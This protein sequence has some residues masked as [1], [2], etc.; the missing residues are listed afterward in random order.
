MSAIA[1]IAEE[2]GGVR[3]MADRMTEVLGRKVAPSTVQYWVEVGYVPQKRVGDV[4]RTAQ[5]AGKTVRQQD[6]YQSIT[7]PSGEAPGEH[8][9]HADGQPKSAA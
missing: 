8:A 7:S 3:S 2:L 9:G 6:L 1:R 4:L 5:A